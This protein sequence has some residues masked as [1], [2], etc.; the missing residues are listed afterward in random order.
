MKE[1]LKNPLNEELRFSIEIGKGYISFDELNSLIPGQCICSNANELDPAYIKING[2]ILCSGE[3]II[4]DKHWGFKI[5]DIHRKTIINEL[6]FP[7]ESLEQM[8]PFSLEACSFP[9]ASV[10]LPMLLK[11]QS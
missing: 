8:I 10:I 4:I 9:D 1:K 6:P 2:E 11:I 5:T 7:V 3:I